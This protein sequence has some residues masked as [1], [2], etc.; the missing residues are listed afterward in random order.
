[1]LT[2]AGMVMGTLGYIAPEQLE[3]SGEP[4]PR[5]DV[6]SL[7]CVLFECLTGRRAFEG[8]HAMAVLAKIMLQ[9][10]PRA[11]AVR[12]EVPVALDA[13][14]AGMRAKARD[15]RLPDAAG[16]ALELDAIDETD[17]G[18]P[19]SVDGRSSDPTVAVASDR[20]PG[21]ITRTEQRRVTVVLARR[22]ASRA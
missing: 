7:G 20:A 4:D 3:T 22:L 18:P 6:F 8:A 1:R 16:V 17:L 9:E 13:R 21:S 15:A 10:T 2:G 11:R 14:A 12:P 19:H 5:S